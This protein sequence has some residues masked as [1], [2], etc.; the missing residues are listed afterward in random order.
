MESE[1]ANEVGH[2]FLS[3]NNCQEQKLLLAHEKVNRRD[4][5]NNKQQT[6]HEKVFFFSFLI[7]FLK[8]K[9]IQFSHANFYFY[10]VRI[11]ASL[12]VPLEQ[13]AEEE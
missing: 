9:K 8:N 13:L 2:C 5:D 6:P 3:H 7:L 12:A 1:S 10:L 11:N 4:D